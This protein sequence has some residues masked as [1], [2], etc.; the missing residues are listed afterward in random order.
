MMTLKLPPPNFPP[1]TVCQSSLP[2]EFSVIYQLKFFFEN[3]LSLSLSTRTIC[4][5]SSVFEKK[6]C[7]SIYGLYFLLLFGGREGNKKQ[8]FDF[9]WSFDSRRIRSFKKKTYCF[10]I[11]QEIQIQLFCQTISSSVVISLSSLT[12]L[13]ASSAHKQRGASQSFDSSL[14]EEWDRVVM[15]NLDCL[16]NT[17]QTS[18]LVVILRFPQTVC[19][20]VCF[21][22]WPVTNRALL[23]RQWSVGR[24]LNNGV[25]CGEVLFFFKWL[26]L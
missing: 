22:C 5:V 20:C 24:Y 7:V 6:I 25:S 19:V 2:I 13:A 15:E 3:I 1:R 18:R 11:V 17:C 12:L 21:S 23:S 14:T 26:Q 8:S 4:C 9:N 16:S 10:V